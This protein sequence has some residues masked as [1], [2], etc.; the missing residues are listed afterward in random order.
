MAQRS[1]RLQITEAE[2]IER[3]RVAIPLGRW[4]EPSDIANA[5]AF[6]CSPQ[7]GDQPALM[8]NGSESMNKTRAGASGCRT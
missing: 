5:V 8:Y 4:G 3:V 7:A 6:L 2:M 1:Q